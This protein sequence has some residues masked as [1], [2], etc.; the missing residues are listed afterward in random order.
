MANLPMSVAPVHLVFGQGTAVSLAQG[1][2]PGRILVSVDP[3]DIGEVAPFGSHGFRLQRTVF[4]NA[5]EVAWERNPAFVDHLRNIIAKDTFWDE[6]PTQ[7]LESGRPQFKLW[8]GPSLS[9]S[10]F[11]IRVIEAF[12]SL[13]HLHR[14]AVVDQ[15]G[16]TDLRPLDVRPPES[17]TLLEASAVALL[18]DDAER[19]VECSR[20]FGRG[21]WVGFHLLAAPPIDLVTLHRT[22]VNGWTECD[23]AIVR[24]VV[25]QPLIGS[26]DILGRVLGWGL[27]H[28]APVNSMAVLWRLRVLERAGVLRLSPAGWSAALSRDLPP[29]PPMGQRWAFG[30]DA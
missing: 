1:G 7:V 8:W 26:A 18:P 21:D 9:E 29:L 27:E 30:C 2:I 16:S 28:R 17:L 11:A 4:W 14:L 3:L 25:D 12:A 5:L 19:W 15:G 20:C 10:L 13:G 22:G 6:L 23:R 24:L